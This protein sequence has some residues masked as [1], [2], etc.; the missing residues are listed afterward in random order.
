MLKRRLKEPFGKAGLTVAVLA[1]VLAMVGG[2][3]AAAGLNS[4][5]KK[6]VTKIA[7]K[8]AGKPGAPGANGTNGAPGAPGA[9]GTNGAPG[10]AGESVAIT[11]SAN[12]FGTHCNNT[13]TGK[14]GTK[15][16]VGA[17]ESFACNGK[18]GSPW[19]AGGFLPSG[20]SETGIYSVGPMLTG[21]GSFVFPA[22]TFPI[23]LAPSAVV[24]AH[25]INAAGEEI[26][27]ESAPTAQTACL[28]SV[29]DP[30]AEKGNFC[31]YKGGEAGI[32]TFSEGV[33]PYN[34]LG[35]KVQFLVTSPPSP[36]N[37]VAADGSWAVTAP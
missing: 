35:V 30:T 13:T 24:T 2:A 21:A 16:K 33:L 20:S 5:Q 29:G 25:Y 1:L 23:R 26:H 10:A 19:T 31:L 15:F 8:Y 32:E 14:G 37:E 3:W 17:T 22:A 9:N 27:F 36:E 11:E 18:E 6:E 28:G 4:K 34:G 7:K 12:A